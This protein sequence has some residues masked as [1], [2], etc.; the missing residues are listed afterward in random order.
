M[1]CVQS[2]ED[3]RRVVSLRILREDLLPEFASLDVSA[4]EL[5]YQLHDESDAI[6]GI[7]YRGEGG[8]R[9]ARISIPPLLGENLGNCVCVLL[10]AGN[11]GQG[12][13]L[14]DVLA[15]AITIKHQDS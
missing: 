13:L 9:I 5:A 6:I 2:S 7:Q 14:I 1:V 15:G 3:A 10:P 8:V 12:T 11:G 4:I